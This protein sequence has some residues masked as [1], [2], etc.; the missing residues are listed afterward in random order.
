M[1]GGADVFPKELQG[2]YTSL[3]D[4]MMRISYDW[5]AYAHIITFLNHLGKYPGQ[6][7]AELAE[8]WKNEYPRRTTILDALKRAGY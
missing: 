6:P 4:K 2:A 1:G 8:R 5:Q 7:D 3:I